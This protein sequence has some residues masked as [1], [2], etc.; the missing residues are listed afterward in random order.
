MKT[1][2]VL[3]GALACVFAAACGSSDD[4]SSAGGQGGATADGAAGSGGFD[5]ASGTG[6]GGGAGG[7]AGVDASNDGP[8][9]AQGGAS[10]DAA[11]DGASSSDGSEGAA[12]CG[13]YAGKQYFNCAPDGMGRGK[14]ESGSLTFEDCPRGCLIEPVGQDDVCLGTT[15]SWSCSGSYG[16]TKLEDGDY[17]ATSFGCWTDASSTVHTDPGDNCIPGCLSQAQ[18]DG[19]CANMSGPECEESVNWYAADA[20]RFGCM[21]RLRVENPANGK[22]VVVVA[23]DYGPACWVEQSVS[24]GI[25]DL[26]GRVNQYLF[27]GDQGANDKTLVHVIEV[28]PSTPLGPI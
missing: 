25:V 1:W 19:L 22:A 28:D 27:G 17:Y 12:G 14:C 9:D 16:K 4:A 20:G 10:G 8:T 7:T 23:L 3:G 26:S 15:N 5:G 11:D 18:S 13:I 21:A 24:H 6:G 2:I